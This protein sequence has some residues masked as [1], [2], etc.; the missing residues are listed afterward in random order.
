[1]SK[2]VTA[3]RTR[4]DKGDSRPIKSPAVIVNTTFSAA[5]YENMKIHHT[6]TPHT[7]TPHTNT[8]PTKHAVFTYD[9]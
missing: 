5:R 2:Y 7:H 1:M 9:I 4:V 3:S 6:H 8:L